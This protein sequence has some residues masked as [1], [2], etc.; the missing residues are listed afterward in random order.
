MIMQRYETLYVMLCFWFDSSEMTEGDKKNTKKKKK[1]K[2]PKLPMVGPIA[3]VSSV[4]LWTFIY[5]Q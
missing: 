2:P 1:E 3:V 4:I 5:V